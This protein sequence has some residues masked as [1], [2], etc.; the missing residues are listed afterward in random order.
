LRNHHPRI[1]YIALGDTDEAA[2]A[3]HYD[4]Y[5]DAARETDQWLGELWDFLQNDPTYRNR[6]TLLITTDHGRG[7]ETPRQWRRHRAGICGA[8]QIWLAA[9]GPN[10]PPI[11]RNKAA[12]ATASATNCQ[13]HCAVGRQHFPRSSSGSKSHRN[14]FQEI[15][16]STIDYRQ[17]LKSVFLAYKSPKIV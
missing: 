5:L 7:Y 11:G 2:H 13:H 1:A 10:T 3:G 17:A 15:S 12:N 6:T 9:I 8:D 16:R 14:H 4:R